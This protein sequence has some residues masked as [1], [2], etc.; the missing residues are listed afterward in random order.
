MSIKKIYMSIFVY[1]FEINFKNKEIDLLQDICKLYHEIW[2]NDRYYLG[3][4]P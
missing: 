4:N 3:I 1:F 2:Q